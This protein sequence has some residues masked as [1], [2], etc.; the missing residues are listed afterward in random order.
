MKRYEAIRAELRELYLRAFR[1]IHEGAIGKFE[2][3]IARLEAEAA[4]LLHLE[5][6]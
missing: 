3:R 5:A 2:A 1:A 4:V 6:V